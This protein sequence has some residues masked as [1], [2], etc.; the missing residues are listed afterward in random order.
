MAQ[1]TASIPGV[2]GGIIDT[3]PIG[4]ALDE[5]LTLRT[6]QT[7]AHRDMRELLARIAEGEIDP[8]FVISHRLSLNEAPGAHAMF[9]KQEESCIKVVLEP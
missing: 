3:F 2:H 9:E 4:A 1:S 5:G 8:S 6:G 7:H